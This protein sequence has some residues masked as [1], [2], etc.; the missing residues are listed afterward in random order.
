[1]VSA[2][3]LIL[4]GILLLALVTVESGGYFLT[5]SRARRVS[6]RTACS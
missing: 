1:M 5:R 3:D 2:D 4:I 6:R